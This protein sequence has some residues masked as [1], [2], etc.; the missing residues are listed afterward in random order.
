MKTKKLVLEENKDYRALVNAVISRIGLES[1]SDV[2]SHGISGGFGGFI[3]YTDTHAFA[4]RYRR[5]IIPMLEDDAK[6]MGY[7]NAA[8]LVASFNCLQNMDSDDYKDLYRYL[9]GSR[10]EQCSVTNALAW[11]AAETVCRW[12][13]D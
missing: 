1:V 13:E 9:G 2:N 7:A 3:Y 6:E 5:F 11:Y 12:F 4:M 10:V 8:E